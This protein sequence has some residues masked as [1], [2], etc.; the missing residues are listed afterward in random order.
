MSYIFVRNHRTSVQLLLTFWMQIQFILQ[1]AITC[2][3]VLHFKKF[4][5]QINSYVLY[6]LSNNI[7]VVLPIFLIISH[8]VCKSSLYSNS[9]SSI[10]SFDLIHAPS[11]YN[12][13]RTFLLNLSTLLFCTKTCFVLM[14]SWFFLFGM[15]VY[16]MLF[17]YDRLLG[18]WRVELSGFWERLSSSSNTRQVIWSSITYVLCIVVL[19]SYAQL[20]AE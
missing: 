18:V 15:N 14:F 17:V 1:F 13:L 5:L 7:H 3:V 9:S 4:I 20:H 12:T 10:T 8:S 2:V 6:Y 16:W 11:L 19:P